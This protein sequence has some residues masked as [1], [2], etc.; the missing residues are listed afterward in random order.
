MNNYCRSPYLPSVIYLTRVKHK[1]LYLQ[2]GFPL[3]SELSLLTKKQKYKLNSIWYSSIIEKPLLTGST[4]NFS[5]I[6]SNYRVLLFNLGQRMLTER[7][8]LC[9]PSS[10]LFPKCCFQQEQKSI[11]ILQGIVCFFTIRYFKRWFN[12][13]HNYYYYYYYYYYY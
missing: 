4:A 3:W 11:F 12:G 9:M 5:I 7:K 13:P 8:K 2:E 10:V 1:L 6:N